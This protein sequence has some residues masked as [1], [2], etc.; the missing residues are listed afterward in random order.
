[1]SSSEKQENVVACVLRALAWQAAVAMKTL[2]ANRVKMVFPFPT[3]RVFHLAGCAPVAPQPFLNWHV[4]RQ[5]RIPSAT[6]AS[7]SSC[8]GELT[9]QAGCVR[10]AGCAVLEVERLGPVVRW[11]ILYVSGASQGLTPKRKATGNP[12][13]LVHAVVKTRWSSDPANLTLTPS[14]W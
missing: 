11:E 12:V 1:M 6:V 3:P 4:A 5:S 8:G 10:L 7:I 2:N 13:C 9:V 14:V